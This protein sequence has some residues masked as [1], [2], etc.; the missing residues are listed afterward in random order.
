MGMIFPVGML[1]TG[2]DFLLGAEAGARR[3]SSPGAGA[4]AEATRASAAA[5]ESYGREAWSAVCGIAAEESV[6]NSEGGKVVLESGAGVARKT[7]D[8][9]RAS[10]TEYVFPMNGYCSLRERLC[11]C[12]FS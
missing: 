3:G 8:Q 9:T 7:T 10:N 12:R 6:T 4:D 5:R 1:L 11:L 2:A